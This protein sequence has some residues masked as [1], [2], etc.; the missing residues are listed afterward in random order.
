[1][2]I[3]TILAKLALVAL[4]AAFSTTYMSACTENPLDT[5]DT[6]DAGE[7]LPLPMFL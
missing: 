1:M 5:S 2:K 7:L 6:T 3:R 4:F